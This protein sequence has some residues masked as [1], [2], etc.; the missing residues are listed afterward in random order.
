MDPSSKDR[1]DDPLYQQQLT[2]LRAFNHEMLETEY[3]PLKGS[4]R[5]CLLGNCLDFSVLYGACIPEVN[6]VWTRC[7]ISPVICCWIQFSDI[8]LRAWQLDS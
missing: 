4:R 6:P 5:I 3:H 8:L 7:I 1:V 2:S